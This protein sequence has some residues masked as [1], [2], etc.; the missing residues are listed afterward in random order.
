MK[1][2]FYTVFAASFFFFNLLFTDTSCLSNMFVTSITTIIIY[3]VAWALTVCAQFEE[4]IEITYIE[5]MSEGVYLQ[6]NDSL[7]EYVYTILT[8]YGYKNKVVPIADAYIERIE[9]NSSPRIEVHHRE[10]RNKILKV[11]NVFIS[12][13]YIFYIPADSSIEVRG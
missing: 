6:H 11:L 2:N 10:P 8:E 5:P 3:I 9:D 12:P 4:V 13:Y 7:E 1:F